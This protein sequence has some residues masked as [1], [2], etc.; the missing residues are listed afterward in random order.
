MQLL[1]QTIK[2]VSK[3]TTA[4]DGWICHIEQ[5]IRINKHDI[6]INA[7]LAYYIN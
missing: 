6:L 5:L 3:K 4:L 2:C 1:A 7:K